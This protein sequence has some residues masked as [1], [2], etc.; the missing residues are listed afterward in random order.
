MDVSLLKRLKVATKLEDRDI[1]KRYKMFNKQ[2]PKG[3]VSIAEFR[4]MSLAVLEDP[5]EVDDFV[6]NV[7]FIFDINIPARRPMNFERFTLATEMN[8]ISGNILEKLSWLFDH[9][10]YYDEVRF[11]NLNMLNI[12]FL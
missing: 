3:K 11:Y 12:L 4:Q 6:T 10:Y 2:F 8:A 1:V 9:V 5:E 7:F